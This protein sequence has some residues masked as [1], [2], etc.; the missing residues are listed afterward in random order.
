MCVFHCTL[1][2]DIYA[3]GPSDDVGQLQLL[4]SPLSATNEILELFTGGLI[5]LNLAMPA[6]LHSIGATKDQID[7]AVKNAMEQEL[8]ARQLEKNNSNV[9]SKGGN[10]EV[11]KSRST[12][13]N[14]TLPKSDDDSSV[15]ESTD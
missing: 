2:Q 11:K 9:E 6:V 1:L 14:K 12:E 8:Q 4:T 7:T 5:P 13:N 10:S 3:Q 15:D